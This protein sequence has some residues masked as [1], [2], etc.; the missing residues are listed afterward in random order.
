MGKWKPK[1]VRILQVYKGQHYAEH[2]GLGSD[3]RLYVWSH[4]GGAWL[5]FWLESDLPNEPE[6]A[7]K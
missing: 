5:K 7:E 6:G 3:G 1:S 2:F 4:N